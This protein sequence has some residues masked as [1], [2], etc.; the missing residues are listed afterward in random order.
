MAKIPESPM[1][2]DSPALLRPLA[3]PPA[4]PEFTMALPIPNA[5]A[6]VTYISQLMESLAS[7]CV[8]IPR[9]II[10]ALAQRAVSRRVATPALYTASIATA[11]KS[12]GIRSLSLGGVESSSSLSKAKHRVLSLLSLTKFWPASSNNTSPACRTILPGISFTLVP[13]LCTAMTAQLN[14]VLNLLCLMLLPTRGPFLATTA[15][16]SLLSELC[17]I[18]LI[19]SVSRGAKPGILRS[20]PMA[21]PEP[22]HQS[23]SFSMRTSS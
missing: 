6:I 19:C 16:T 20:S 9:T 10:P 8:K 11:R 14:L 15:C 17:P 7:C 18:L 12:A 23:M 13:S 22:L 21:L 5:A 4:T 2:K 3:T 1:P